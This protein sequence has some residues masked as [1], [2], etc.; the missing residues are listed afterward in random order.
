M[1]SEIHSLVFEIPRFK[2]VHINEVIGNKLE[3]EE[4][5]VKRLTEVSK[6]LLSTFIFTVSPSGLQLVMWPLCF[7]MRHHRLRFRKPNHFLGVVGRRKV[8]FLQKSPL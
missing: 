5:L 1:K 4:V 3:L 6:M 2:Y 8:G 7:A